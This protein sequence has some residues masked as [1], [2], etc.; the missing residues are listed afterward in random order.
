MQL[1]YK[2]SNVLHNH[3]GTIVEITGIEHKTD[4]PQQG[5]SRDYWFYVG[6]VR[7]DDNGQESAGHIDPGNMCSDTQ[8][9]FKEIVALNELMMAYLNA[10]GEWRESGPQGWYAHRKTKAKAV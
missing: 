7:W 9:G 6:R 1:P 2:P 10:N 3:G 4:R 8:D 5:Y